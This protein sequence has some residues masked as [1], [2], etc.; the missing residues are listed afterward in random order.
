MLQNPPQ[1]VYSVGMAL[2]VVEA[3]TKADAAYV[4]LRDAIRAGKLAPGERL[5]LRE[6]A[7]DLGMSFTPVRDA[8]QVLASQGLVEH[9]AHVGTVVALFT[10]ERAQEVYRLRNLL[11]PVAARLGTERATTADMEYA[12]DA[13][14][15]LGLALDRDHL[16]ELPSRNAAF[17][18]A[19]YA[20]SGSPY[21]KEFIDRLWNGLPF[22]AISLASRAQASHEE[23]RAILSA[24]QRGEADR[25]AELV[26]EHIARGASAMFDSG[27][28][29][30]PNR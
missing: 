22:Q 10:W 9:R 6:I 18:R 8:L 16:A 30:N 28:I 27:A 11:E 5:M 14:D 1:I 7:R 26:T 24:F 2:E 13:F 20:P 12:A 17:H 4:A 29:S 15:Q 3:R 21:L 19:I 23:H 25:C